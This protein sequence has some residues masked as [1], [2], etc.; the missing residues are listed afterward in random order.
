MNTWLENS[1]NR[2]KAGYA[3]I[4]LGVVF[5]LI[6]WL[7]VDL[8][9]GMWPLFIVGPGALLTYLANRGQLNNVGL[10]FPGMILLGTGGILFYQ[11]LTGHWASWAYA[12]ALYPALIG[13]SLRFQ[14]ERRGNDSEIKTGRE[15]IKWSLIAFVGLWL[16]FELLIF[17][18]I[19]GFAWLLLII[20][21]FILLQQR[22]NSDK[23]K[24][25]DRL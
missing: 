12:W 1:D 2:T 7:N 11:N 9:G 19:G 8:F 3:L 24:N 10:I 14:G 21:G 18:N 20:G 13:F 25:D 6:Q 16:F 17:G 23:P 22:R 4:G 5:L 15:M